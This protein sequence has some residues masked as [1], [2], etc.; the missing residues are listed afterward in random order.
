MTPKTQP[1]A[2]LGEAREPG[3]DDHRS[4]G[5]LTERLET[6]GLWVSALA[7]CSRNLADGF[8]SSA[9]G[10]EAAVESLER[11]IYP[12]SD[13]ERVGIGEEQSGVQ[14]VTRLFPRRELDLLILAGSPD[15]GGDAGRKGDGV[16]LGELLAEAQVRAKS[17]PPCRRWRSRR[18]IEE[19]AATTTE[20]VM[21]EGS[22]G[23]P[24]E[25]IERFRVKLFGPLEVEFRDRRLGPSGFPG[26]KP[27]QI[28]EILLIRRGQLVSNEQL[29][30]ALWGD[31]LPLNVSATLNTYVSILRSS[32]DPPR[33]AGRTLI[34][35]APGAYRLEA[36][37]VDVDL[38]RFDSLVERAH[39]EES[40]ARALLAEALSLV[41]G[42]VLQDEPYLDGAMEIRERY[43][44]R[45]LDACLMA[46]DL[47]LLARDFKSGLAY[48]TKILATEPLDEPAYQVAMIASYALG[49]QDRALSFY[50]RCH[51][52]L[53]DELGVEPTDETMALHA[54]ILGRVPLDE[55]LSL[56]RLDPGL[57]VG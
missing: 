20:V 57:A 16:S 53:V 2:V 21:M 40:E 5:N 23:A 9:V 52:T 22:T 7:Y 37:Q 39:V 32:L 19:V 13:L 31:D 41:R 47:A 44:L 12:Q 45:W 11:A 48:A 26:I 24:S 10:I 56:H 28:L 50:A 1:D 35:T 6:I 38:D 14:S 36:E 33:T 15:E 42:E 25:A 43:R 55:L 30:E 27:K 54:A 51:K 17:P 34:V 18:T 4:T 46:A 8:A 49:R 3:A 29:A